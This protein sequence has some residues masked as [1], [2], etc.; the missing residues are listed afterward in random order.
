MENRQV[1]TA[2]CVVSTDG[3][4]H[5][6]RDRISDGL[7]VFSGLTSMHLR[8]VWCRYEALMFTIGAG[9]FMFVGETVGAVEM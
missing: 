6:L 7:L 4:Q 5:N 1:Y 8:W 3:P 2:I 9:R